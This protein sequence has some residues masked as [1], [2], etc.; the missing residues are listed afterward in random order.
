MKRRRTMEKNDVKQKWNYRLSGILGVVVVSFFLF[1]ACSAPDSDEAPD[2]SSYTRPKSYIEE[3]NKDR[4]EAIEANINKNN[5]S[6]SAKPESTPTP[7]PTEKPEEKPDTADMYV[8]AM[9][10]IDDAI[11]KAS[12]SKKYSGYSYK[13]KDKKIKEGNNG[14]GVVYNVSFIIEF[15]GV[16]QKYRV[17]VQLSPMKDYLMGGYTYYITDTN[18]SHSGSTFLDY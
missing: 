8:A 14:L 5:S 16:F 3:Y 11:S 13:I 15:N 9:E 12:V 17:D 2:D 7:K 1:G 4:R 6:Q 10:Q 18:V